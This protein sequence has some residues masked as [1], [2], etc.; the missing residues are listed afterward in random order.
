MSS[1]LSPQ[2]EQ[3]HASAV[4][5]Q[6]EQVHASP[7]SPQKEQVHASPVSPQKEQVHASAVS[8][9][10]EQVHASPVSL[11]KEQ[12]HAS[13]VSPQK[14]QVHASAVSPKKEQAQLLID[15]ENEL[16]NI[17]RLY[18]HGVFSEAI[19]SPEMIDFIITQFIDNDFY[20]K[21]RLRGIIHKRDKQLEILAE[22]VRIFKQDYLEK[23]DE[24]RIG[25]DPKLI[26]GDGGYGNVYKSNDTTAKKFVKKWDATKQRYRELHNLENKGTI[27]FILWMIEFCTYVVVISIVKYV[28]CTMIVDETKRNEC[29][30][31]R[32]KN[33]FGRD[34]YFLNYY[35]F[36]ANI[37]KPF[38]RKGRDR[39]E[40]Y[41]GYYI[42]KYNN[43]LSKNL[44][45]IGD[46]GLDVSS[47]INL[48]VQ[49]FE[50]LKKLHDLSNI[51]II[52]SH[53]DFS[54][55]NI[56][57]TD[58]I[59]GRN[60]HKIRIIDFG[61]ICVNIKFK[62][63]KSKTFGYHPFEDYSML[64]LCDKKCI[65]VIFLIN[66][67]IEHHTSFLK[68][69]E[70]QYGLV[71]YGKDVVEL[72][73]GLIA[74][75]PRSEGIDDWKYAALSAGAYTEKIFKDVFDVLGKIKNVAKRRWQEIDFE[76]VYYGQVKQ[77]DLNNQTDIQKYLEIYN[78]NK[79]N[80]LK[81]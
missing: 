64:H 17:I 8:P 7:V 76:Q 46:N 74:Q 35:S 68:S 57:F 52:L 81:M 4:S 45:V 13:P 71:Q 59:Y 75:T 50:I 19:L 56:M 39:D 65:D 55:N 3:A 32:Y 31:T 40:Y 67:I 47:S 28:D 2:K 27:V 36:M 37:K 12:V 33:V 60:S 49:T 80:Y 53:R 63:G 48:L 66:W 10:K 14:E 21:G 16:K 9:Q 20:D 22:F 42:E 6:K 11:Q 23:P 26:I 61:Y 24:T 38:I 73:R 41:I 54:T 78:A 69:V 18:S 51:G 29:I 34:E 72:F 5:P 43:S 15:D 79:Q 25:N 62:D 44:D 30:Q 1:I 58:D 70:N 77:Y